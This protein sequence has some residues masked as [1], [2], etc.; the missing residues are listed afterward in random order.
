MAFENLGECSTLPLYTPSVP[1]PE[2]SY[3][4]A[5]DERTLQST[6]SIHHPPPTGTYTKKSRKVTV[7]LFEQEDDAKIP[8]F[9]RRGLI[10]G[11]IYLENHELI[12]RVV[13][14]V[15]SM[16]FVP[17]Q[18]KLTSLVQVE[19][20]LESTSTERA[21]NSTEILNHRYT[22]WRKKHEDS[23]C[24]TLVPFSCVLPSTFKHGDS[25]HP[26]PPSFTSHSPAFPTLFV[27]SHYSVRVCVEKACHH[28]IKFL[29]KRKE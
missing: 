28:K 12:Y 25:E 2:Y 7:T 27:R 29:T 11:T 22:L 8:T 9:G 20:K 26:L 21:A 13:L 14:K 1:S 15:S 5:Y 17:L 24:P 3:D 23:T 18:W 10:T 6:P 16:L 19:G 4:P